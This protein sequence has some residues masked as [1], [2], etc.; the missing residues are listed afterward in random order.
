VDYRK[1]LLSKNWVAVFESPEVQKHIKSLM[2]TLRQA[3]ANDTAA[4]ANAQGRLDELEYLYL[5]LPKLVQDVMEESKM[6]SPNPGE[7]AAATPSRAPG[8]DSAMEV[9]SPS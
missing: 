9:P 5:K 1:T 8:M 6:F 2:G 3:N 7:D 4:I